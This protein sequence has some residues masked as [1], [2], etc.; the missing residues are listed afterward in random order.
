[1][2]SWLSYIGAFALALGAAT[3]VY[4]AGFMALMTGVSSGIAGVVVW[5]VL[6]PMAAALIVFGVGY[7]VFTG[8]WL[9]GRRWVLAA[10]FVLFVAI[11]GFV[12]VAQD[13]AEQSTITLLIILTLFFGG[14]FLLKRAFVV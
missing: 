12:L 5:V 2:R 6:A 4:L 13:V 14:R 1:M 11:T 3:M 7:G 9:S 10:G 8:H